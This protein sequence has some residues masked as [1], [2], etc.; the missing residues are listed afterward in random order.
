MTTPELAWDHLVLDIPADG[1]A[2]ERRATPEE[3][4]A[5]AKTLE[6][7]GCS[8]LDAR[9]AI[10]PTGAGRFRV[11]GSL[12]AKVEQTCVVTLAP[13]T[14]TITESFDFEFWPDT[15]IP[16]PEGGELDLS[17]EPEREPIVA[18]QIHVG[19]I[20]FECLASAIDLFPRAP[21]AK[22]DWEAPAAPSGA[23]GPDS[24][25]AVL[26]KIKPGGPAKDQN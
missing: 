24:P 22:L 4:S 9:Y 14:N 26:A 11:S 23:A 19:R 16:A 7:N 17:D 10:K 6:L 3:R 20:V 25:F 21:D 12:E 5:I 8:A 18:G 1:L 13:L 15:D 2:V